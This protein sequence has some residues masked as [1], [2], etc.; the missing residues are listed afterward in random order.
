MRKLMIGCLAVALSTG[1][2]AG[3]VAGAGAQTASAEPGRLPPLVVQATPDYDLELVAGGDGELLTA[4]LRRT[5]LVGNSVFPGLDGHGSLSES[6]WG[7]IGGR[8]CLAASSAGTL[9]FTGATDRDA[10]YGLAGTGV[11]RIELVL[12]DGTEIVARRGQ[13]THDGLRGWIAVVPTGAVVERAV[14]YN[15][16]GT[17]VAT[18]DDL[19]ESFGFGTSSTCG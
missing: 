10:S 17:E 2:V 9:R 14:A 4:A 19:D 5:D 8:R 11:S 1:A 15:A 3:A 18:A 12:T 13:A 6:G 16:S 7:E